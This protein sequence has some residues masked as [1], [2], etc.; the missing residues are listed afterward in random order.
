MVKHWT[1]KMS[2][3]KIKLKMKKSNLMVLLKLETQNSQFHKE[4]QMFRLTR[5]NIC[6]R[7]SLMFFFQNS[8]FR[9]NNFKMI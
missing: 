9:L 6:R 1:K 8:K 5:R 3:L 7:K 2:P 4:G